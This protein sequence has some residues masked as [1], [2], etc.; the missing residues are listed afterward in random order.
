MANTCALEETKHQGFDA[1]ILTNE[2]I[3]ACV[4]P[5]LGG[6]ITSIRHLLTEREW[7]WSNPYLP[8]QPVE[9]GASFTEKYD[10]GGLDE[11]FPAVSGDFNPRPG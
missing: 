8:L 6:K 10:T 7:L 2:H 1:Y 4:I 5:D 3:R 9:Y 11:C